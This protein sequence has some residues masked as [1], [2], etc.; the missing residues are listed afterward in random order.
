MNTLFE[1]ATPCGSARTTI[2]WGTDGC[3][4]CFTKP[5]IPI[6]SEND[7]QRPSARCPRRRRAVSGFPLAADDIPRTCVCWGGVGVPRDRVRCYICCPCAR[8]GKWLW[9]SGHLIRASLGLIRLPARAVQLCE[10]RLA[11]ID[12]SWRTVAIKGS[13]GEGQ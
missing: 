5:I 8:T 9:A 10:E 2:L 12:S 6:H 1:R 11:N 7:F 4:G 3:V 13:R